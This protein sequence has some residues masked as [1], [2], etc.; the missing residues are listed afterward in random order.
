LR[1]WTKEEL[2]LL[3]KFRDEEVALR[4]GHP[5]ASVKTK[6][7]KLGIGLAQPKRRPWT[8]AEDAVLGTDTDQAIAH[9]LGRDKITVNIR[10]N[11]LGISSFRQNSASRP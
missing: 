5:A 11:K 10:R 7:Q 2:A 6:R 4:T 3:G 8:S 1:P 9:R